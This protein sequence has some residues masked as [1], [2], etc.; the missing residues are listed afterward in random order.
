MLHFQLAG[1]RQQ[2]P[3][4]I[5]SPLQGSLYRQASQ[6]PADSVNHQVSHNG[7]DLNR[8]PS[9]SYNGS[10]VI[11][12]PSQ[13]PSVQSSAASQATGVSTMAGTVFSPQ[14][15]RMQNS[16]GLGSPSAQGQI[17]DKV[18]PF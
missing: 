16:F 11:Y 5:G 3:I 13:T 17:V 12:V 8:Q 2:S 15:G 7:T 10:G 1:T 6:L 18:G 9:P 4:V 14:R